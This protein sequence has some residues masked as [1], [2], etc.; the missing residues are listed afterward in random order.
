MTNPFDEAIEKQVRVSVRVMIAGLLAVDDRA[1]THP[2]FF[3]ILEQEV[4]SFGY[5]IVGERGVT[6]ADINPRIEE[7]A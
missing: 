6:L 7:D 4:K 3:A 2:E 1:I 5:R